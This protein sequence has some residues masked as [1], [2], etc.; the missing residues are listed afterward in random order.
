MEHFS[1]GEWSDYVRG[2]HSQIDF[3]IMRKH[4]TTGCERC[5]G[6]RSRMEQ[7][8]T[9]A[10][11]EIELEVPEA[12]VNRIKQLAIFQCPEGVFAG[13]RR[14]CDLMFDSFR[15]PFAL[16]V[17]NASHSARQTLYSGSGYSVD[18]QQNAV[19]G[20]H[21]VRLIG[22]VTWKS[23]V[24]EQSAGTTVTLKAGA[25]VLARAV[26]NQFGEFQM[27]YVPGR[28]FRIVVGVGGQ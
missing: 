28:R 25:E 10:R 8:L 4:L 15:E 7:V 22:Q 9:F 27:E 2:L 23:G 6:E 5:N 20:G 11:R 21:A 17:R 3:E 16:G 18:V 26:T 12:E 14:I 1:L 13:A 24:G 19:S